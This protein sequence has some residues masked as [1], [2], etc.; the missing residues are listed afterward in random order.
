MQQATR[1][2]HDNEMSTS[3][4]NEPVDKRHILSDI[5]PELSKDI[6]IVLPRTSAKA[7]STTSAKSRRTVQSSKA[8]EKSENVV[9]SRGRPM[10]PYEVKIQQCHHIFKIMQKRYHVNK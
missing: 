2:G 5:D 9:R 3:F 10:K 6:D 8:S 4:Q 1:K 7:R